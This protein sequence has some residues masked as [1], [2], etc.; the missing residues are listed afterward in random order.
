[1]LKFILLTFCGMADDES[2]PYLCVQDQGVDPNLRDGDGATPLHFAA[3]RGHLSVV[4]WLLNHGAKLS[5]DKYGKS[6]INDAAENQQ[7]ECLNVLV[8]HVPT[9]DGLYV[10]PMRMNGIYAPPSPNG[11]MSGDSFFLHDPQE[12][13]YNRVR[14]LFDSDSS[15]VKH[16]NPHK[17][18]QQQKH[19][20]HHQQQHQHGSHHHNSKN[21]SSTNSTPSTTAMTI[22]ADVHSSSSGGGSGSEE[23]I[24]IASSLNS[25]KVQLHR[26]HSFN[27][28]TN[29]SNSNNYQHQHQHNNNNNNNNNNVLNNNKTNSTANN[30]NN[31]ASNNLLIHQNNHKNNNKHNNNNS[32]NNNNGNNK[33]NSH[34]HDYED[35]YLVREEARKNQQKKY[36][37]G[38]SRS[39]DSG[40][41]SRSASAS[42]TRSTDVVMQYSNHNLNNKRDSNVLNRSKSQSATGLHSKYESALRSKDNYS[43]NGPPPP[44]LPPPLRSPAHQHGDHHNNNFSFTSNQSNS[45]NSCHRTSNSNL[46][47]DT[48]MDSDSGLEVIEEPSL[49][50]SELV[51]GNHNRTMSTI[52]GIGFESLRKIKVW[53][54]SYRI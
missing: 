27:H 47:S 36:I 16:S 30:N 10:N 48:G 44:P 43:V 1:M 53:K 54:N 2:P 41:H 11:S 26:K 29:N 6:P 25:P 32:N 40:S 37:I 18:Q 34:D 51:R 20:Q 9:N 17:Q 35:I 49:R 3:S 50:P 42:S 14:D 5:L 8:Q 38:R 15:S 28:Q 45:L 4:R 21:S 39:R 46:H 19:H 13:V 12:V 7:V 23:S 24:S 52:S 31:N 33:S 22:Q